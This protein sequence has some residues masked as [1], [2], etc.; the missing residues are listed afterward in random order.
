M[1]LKSHEKILYKLY[2]QVDVMHIPS[3]PVSKA[4]LLK[5]GLSENTYY[6]YL[7]L[8]KQLYN[9]CF[10]HRYELVCDGWNYD[11]SVMD[12][13]KRLKTFCVEHEMLPQ[14]Q[15][16]SRHQLSNSLPV[17]MENFCFVY[18][19]PKV[20]D[21]I[22]I[23]TL[24][25]FRLQ[26]EL[27]LTGKDDDWYLEKRYG[28][29]GVL[30]GYFEVAHRYS[31]YAG[32]YVPMSYEETLDLSE[33]IRTDISDSE[34]KKANCI[35]HASL[36]EYAHNSDSIMM[37]KL[38]V[39]WIRVQIA[40]EQELQRLQRCRERIDDVLFSIDTLPEEDEEP[41]DEI[42]EEDHILYVHK[43]YII[44][45]KRKHPIEQAVATLYNLSGRDVELNVSHC[46]LCNKFFIHY[47]I[48][49]R[50][51]ERYGAILGNLKMI[52]GETYS[53]TTDV[54][55]EESTLHLCGYSV[56]QKEKMT[57]SDRQTIMA[58]VIDNGSMKKSEVINLI[59]YL[60]ELNHSKAT[61]SQ[62]LQ[63]WED[64]LEFVL[65]YNTSKQERYNIR[66]IA[67]YCKNRFT[68]VKPV[69]KALSEAKTDYRSYI[70]KRV[71]HTAKRGVGTVV[72]VYGG[73]ITVDFE[74]A[75]KQTFAE[76]AIANGIITLYEERSRSYG[77]SIKS[78]SNRAVT[79]A[80]G[81]KP[82]EPCE[83]ASYV[84]SAYRNICLNQQS[85]RYSKTCCFCSL[86]E[87]KSIPAQHS[88][89]KT[90]EQQTKSNALQINI[91]KRE[92]KAVNNVAV[93]PPSITPVPV[94]SNHSSSKKKDKI[95]YVPPEKKPISHDTKSGCIFLDGIIC[96]LLNS[97]CEKANQHC[98][99]YKTK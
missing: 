51:R 91:P 9:E 47:D 95:K 56:A 28:V 70:G 37:H 84:S 55:A 22:Y 96:T 24:D 40:C 60:I 41:E 21:G 50:Y 52:T 98:L 69:G 10:L 54:L 2:E 43:G 62:A 92:N 45:E 31:K 89:S 15:S 20:A 82:S 58:T 85:P 19:Y 74:N 77:G 59:R 72:D 83:F 97:P 93:K 64:D 87:K 65:A 48:Y 32:K 25:D 49:K 26:L 27:L 35:I 90:M 63:K 76:S 18:H 39:P 53:S 46:T 80:A 12:L 33:H 79:T 68:I 30:N 86:Y 1:V 94:I 36:K 6:D 44:C 3:E 23:T 66:K 75:G 16:D 81:P 34:R 71:K 42:A 11:H 78:S 88:Y 67:P 5:A 8:I 57:S 17:E 29:I 73:K 38:L 61:H 13:W 7:D 99:F 4:T 14:D